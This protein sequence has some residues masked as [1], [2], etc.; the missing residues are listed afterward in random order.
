MTIGEKTKI[1][2]LGYIIEGILTADNCSMYT[3]EDA[4]MYDEETLEL[5]DTP[6][7]T[8]QVPQNLCEVVK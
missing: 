5:V 1:V 4:K 3:F 2:Y 6:T 7:T 8:F